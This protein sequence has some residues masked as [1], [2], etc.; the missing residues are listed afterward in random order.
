MNEGLGGR[1]A[2]SAWG[3]RAAW[4][5]ALAAVALVLALGQ[6]ESR[7]PDSAL[8]AAISSD[9]AGRPLKEWIVPRWN[10]LWALQG[11]YREHPAGVFL[12]PAMAA[13]LGYPSEQA[14]YAVNALYQV[15]TLF[16][17][18]ALV[19]HF[20]TRRDAR[21]L[22]TLM[23]LVP[24]AFTY[25]IRANQEQ[26]LL[27]FLLVAFLG[28]ERSRT[29]LKW[30]VLSTAGLA[31]LFLVKGVFVAIAIAACVAWL[32]VRQWW[33][34]DEQPRGRP[35]IGLAIAGVSLLGLAVAYETAYSSVAGER[36]FPWYSARQFGVALATGSAHP[37]RGAL[38]SFA[39]YLG[40]IVWFA[41]PWTVVALI[42]C[43]RGAPRLLQ[44][45]AHRPA[46]SVRDAARKGAALAA[47]V[48]V[49]YLVAFSVFERRA[50]RYIFPAYYCLA[51]WWA[52]YGLRLYPSMR[53]LA[54]RATRALYPYEQAL[55]W[56]CSVL[57]ALVAASLQLPNIKLWH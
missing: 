15:L 20:L 55:V 53:R 5:V 48:A 3:E 33:W 41:A 44:R 37:V 27:M 21:V 47:I 51:A 19:R 49:T 9:I 12:L 25:R 42:G 40:R 17:M 11:L 36:F 4:L 8:Y 10:G 23:L 22:V 38:Y 28:I 2:G 30:A 57:L 29:S 26:P 43:W 54:W 32:A 24:I 35:W 18:M 45:G 31:G 34:P 52:A 50:D 6:Y 1:G 14:A 56:F 39:W 46:G 16:L 7:D 13:R